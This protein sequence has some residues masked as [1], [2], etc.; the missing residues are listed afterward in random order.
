MPGDAI[1]AGFE[2]PPRAALER[3]VRQVR[4]RPTGQWA[5]VLG[6]AFVVI[7]AVTGNGGQVGLG[8]AL[9]AVVVTDRVVVGRA[10]GDV[11]VEA[12]LPPVWVAGDD[13]G[14]LVSVRGRGRPVRVD[15]V[16]PWRGVAG[17]A[18]PGDDGVMPVAGPPRGL[19][20]AVTAQLW[21]S[22]PLGLVEATQRVRWWFASPTAI[23]PRD[24][25]VA[26]PW[27]EPTGA[28][29][30]LD[31]RS[32]R[33]Q[34]LTRGVRDYRP[35]DPRRRVHWKATARTGQ[36]MV[37]ETE[38][39]AVGVLTVVVAFAVP[40]PAAEA[41]AERA[42]WTAEE[43]LR[44]GWVVHLVTAESTLPAGAFAP[45]VDHIWAGA[46]SGPGGWLSALGPAVPARVVDARVTSSVD[47]LRRL[48]AAVP[49]EVPVPRRPGAVRVV[50][51]AG[52]RWR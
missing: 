31:A 18:E 27:P 32:P 50:T 12:A 49:G 8:V 2:G 16:D 44:R 11:T 40:G 24:Q 52:D 39:E 43:G 10:L 5:M 42:R 9:V 51:D 7:G 1:P 37:R 21:V 35:G 28:L 38:G 33:G 19:V 15:L 36:L 6:C 29:M 45:D 20:P 26:A 22:G 3:G 25:V 30:G 23:G 34:E 41:A 46:T 4:W 47:V 48:A 17:R 14:L 13:L